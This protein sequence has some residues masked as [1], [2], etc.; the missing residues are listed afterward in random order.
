MTIEE[1]I[2]LRQRAEQEAIQALINLANAITAERDYYRDKCER[3][4]RK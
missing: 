2:K 1:I 3:E 4:E